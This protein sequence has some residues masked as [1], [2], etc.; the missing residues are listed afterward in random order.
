MIKD[1]KKF[2]FLVTDKEYDS[3]FATYEPRVAEQS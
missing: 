2:V 3:L 1:M